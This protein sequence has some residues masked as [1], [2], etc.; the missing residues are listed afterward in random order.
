[1]SDHLEQ[2]EPKGFRRLVGDKSSRNILFLVAGAVVVIV[3]FAFWPSQEAPV[4]PSTV[5]QIPTVPSVQASVPVSPMYQSRLADAD[6]QNSDRAR[7]TGGSALPTPV[8]QNSTSQLPTVI[9]SADVE[10]REAVPERPSPVPPA[11]LPAL[12]VPQTGPVVQQQPVA[13]PL[14]PQP[15]IDTQLASAMT[16]E[17]RRLMG[18]PPAPVV[19]VYANQ[20]AANGQGGNGQ[21]SERNAAQGL[22]SGDGRGGL[23]PASAGRVPP[24]QQASTGMQSASMRS[25]YTVPL[26]GTMLYSRLVGRVNSDV[27]GPVIAEI[28][29]GPYTGARLLGGFRFSEEGVVLSFTSMTV[30]NTENGEDRSE[31]VPINAVAVDAKHLGTAMA[32]DIDRHLFSRVAIAFGTSFLEGLGSVIAR[33]GSTSVVSPLGGATVTTPQ[34]N[35]REQLYVAGGAAAGAVGRI[36]EQ[37][38]GNRRTTVTVDAGTP[39][40]LLFLGAQGSQ[41]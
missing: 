37:V 6:R 25:R 14:P 26:A 18:A 4:A 28:L 40:G 8:L 39:F 21:A 10:P 41:N 7:E 29:Q 33:A 9:E 19:T 35:G 16:A 3:V 22:A 15:Q 38:F 31:V 17:M 32:T 23:P 36:G 30:S 2:Q 24:A 13:Q 12:P 5:G 27:P 20:G 11:A 34:L 1:M